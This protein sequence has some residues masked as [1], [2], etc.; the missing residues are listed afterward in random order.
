MGRQVSVRSL[1][2]ALVLC[3]APAVQHSW[4]ASDTGQFAVK[5]IGRDQCSKYLEAR[6]DRVSAY[7]EYGHYI[8]GYLTATNRL[9]TNT[10]DVTSWESIEIVAAYVANLCRTDPEVRFAEAVEGVLARLMPHRIT[11]DTEI[12][13]VSEDDRSI[14]LYSTV[15]IRVKRAL[16]ERDH[17]DGSID[18]SFDGATVQALR[19]FQEKNDIPA[20]GLPDQR[21]LYLLFRPNS[22]PISD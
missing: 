7:K 13:N 1:S 10:V 19:D 22:N 3:V 5:G 6:E 18:S 14:R 20:T 11:T 17:F 4:A 2:V 8:A 16:M 9:L 12:V 15:I 21:T